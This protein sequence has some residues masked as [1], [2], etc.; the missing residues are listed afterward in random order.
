MG[1]VI[2]KED[3]RNSARRARAKARTEEKTEMILAFKETTA[4]NGGITHLPRQ[5]QLMPL[6]S[7]Y[8][9]LFM[10]MAPSNRSRNNSSSWNVL[11]IFRSG[12]PGFCDMAKTLLHPT[13]L[14]LTLS[15]LFHC[16]EFNKHT[17]QCLTYLTRHNEHTGVYGN[18]NS[19]EVRRICRDER[20]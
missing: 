3:T 16:P 10:S 9:L 12:F 13:S 2:R 17:N 8:V 15:E 7:F 18:I 14:S 19:G 1:K 11:F 4:L 5:L 6:H 20:E